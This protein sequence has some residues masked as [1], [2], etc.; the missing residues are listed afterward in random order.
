MT[1]APHDEA[2]PLADVEINRLLK[3]ATEQAFRETPLGRGGP[4]AAFRPRSLA[5]LAFSNSRQEEA[6]PA[7]PPATAPSEPAPAT[8]L[9]AAE[10]APDDGPVAPPPVPAAAS[11]TIAPPPDP[12]APAPDLE[13]LRSAAW[14]EGYEAGAEAASRQAQARLGA[15]TAAL[16]RAAEQAAALSEASIEALRKDVLRA[17]RRLAAMRAGATIDAQPEAFLARVEAL[18]DRIGSAA[19][20]AELV[21]NADD[22]AAITPHLAEAPALRGVALVAAPGL[23]PGDIMLRAGGIVIEDLLDPPPRS[24]GQAASAPG[25]G[26]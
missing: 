26:A 18:V 4:D 9:A 3:L 15:A 14:Q 24:P 6:P 13:A 1:L 20:Q 12:P 19:R 23:L 5:E 10:A 8:P 11:D 7:Q 17:V 2:R 21:L 22:L 25:D 16:A